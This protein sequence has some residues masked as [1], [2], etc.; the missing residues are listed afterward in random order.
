MGLGVII[1]LGLVSVFWARSHYQNNAATAASTTP[2]LVG[3]T[4]YAGLA[5][6]V[7]GTLEPSLQPSVTPTTA[8]LTALQG[9]VVKV[10]PKLQIQAGKNAN[11]ALFAKNYPGLS[12]TSN[13]ITIP[14][15]GSKPAFTY[16]NGQACPKGTPEAGKTGAV[17]SSFWTNFASKQPQTSTDPTA[18]H[19]TANSLVTVSFVPSGVEAIKPATSTIQAMLAAGA[20]STTTTTAAGVTTTT[21]PVAT[22]TAPVTTTTKK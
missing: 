4:S 16:T 9:G 22:T 1:V 20:S 2:P 21:A 14:A 19:F 10:A 8:P 12:I 7:C 5:F 3:T 17:L 11:I 15:N 6:D 18:I 13:S